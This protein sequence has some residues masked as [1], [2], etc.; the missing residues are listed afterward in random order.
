MEASA[1]MSFKVI[2]ACE[3]FFASASIIQ[4]ISCADA[5]DGSFELTV[6]GGKAPFT[7]EMGGSS[8][9]ENLFQN[10]SAG[11]YEVTIMDA[12]GCSAIVSVELI[13]PEALAITAEVENSTSIFGNGSISITVTGGTGQYTYAWSNGAATASLTELEIGEYSLTVTD[14]NG[15]SLSETFTVGGVTANIEEGQAEWS[16]YPN[17][18]INSLQVQHSEDATQL[19][20][21]DLGGKQ[22]LEQKLE[23]KSSVIEVSQLPTGVYQLKINGNAPK[24]FIKK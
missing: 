18:A 16:F 20:I 6:S 24:R 13:A 11:T 5:S 14:E 4:P 9:S 23:G 2:S 10:M 15:C 7:Y 1:T 22:L 19:S 12:N 3:S 8:Q 17:P 21:Y